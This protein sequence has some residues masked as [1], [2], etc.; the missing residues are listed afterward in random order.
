VLVLA[1]TH[2]RRGGRRRLP[3]EVYAELDRVDA[4]LHAGDV[5][6]SDL[7]HEL[8]GFAP[9]YAVLGN[10][11]HGDLTG[12]LPEVRVEELGGVRVGM[13]HDSGPTKGRPARLRRRFPDCG[14]VV[15]GHSHIP[16]DG[17]GL[18]GQRLFN[19]GSPTERR[20]QPHHTYGVLELA[21]GEIRRHEIRI[22]G[23]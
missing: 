14:L 11:D 6:V 18:G 13:I 1:D 21:G 15:Y 17:E 2:L 22:V 20:A 23:G 5:M 10:N 12:M 4:V 8:G 9:T 3:D 19:P 16:F 7:L